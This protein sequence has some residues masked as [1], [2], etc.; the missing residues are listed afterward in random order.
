M[1]TICLGEAQP[2]EP[3]SDVWTF[4]LYDKHCDIN[5]VGCEI[6]YNDNYLYLLSL[7]TK[8]IV[9]IV[10]IVTTQTTHDYSYP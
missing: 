3:V 9:I 7:V 1:F 4:V 2:K 5:F 8:R 10:T 6:V